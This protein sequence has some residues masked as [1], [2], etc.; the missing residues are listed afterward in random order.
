MAALAPPFEGP[1]IP[2]AQHK[3]FDAV[4]YQMTV[5][6]PG[7]PLAQ[8]PGQIGTGWR[9]DQCFQCPE[10]GGEKVH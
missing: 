8:F 6:L 9:S 5:W 10:V 1:R 7:L 4:L 3:T 2:T